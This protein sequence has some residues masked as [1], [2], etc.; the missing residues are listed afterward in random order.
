M[1]L[2]WSEK[3]RQAG[4]VLATAWGLLI[5]VVVVL[6]IYAYQR[7]AAHPDVA[8][9]VAPVQAGVPHV[10][11]DVPPLEAAPLPE[12]PFIAE[13]EEPAAPPVEEPVRS[14]PPAQQ[15][16]K[17][18]PP[19]AP[20]P[21]AEPKVEPKVESVPV[22]EPAPV[23]PDPIEAPAPEPA[24]APAVVEP[25]P[26]E[27]A[28]AEPAVEEPASPPAPVADLKNV[29]VVLT[30]GGENFT[31]LDVMPAGTAMVLGVIDDNTPRF[32]AKA[33][34]NNIQI[35]LPLPV[36]ASGPLPNLAAE[37]D[38]NRRLFAAFLDDLP[39]VDGLYIP[40]GHPF[41]KDMASFAALL[42]EAKARGLSVIGTIPQNLQTPTTPIPPHRAVDGELL[43]GDAGNLEGVLFVLVGE[44]DAV[45]VLTGPADLAFARALAAVQGYRFVQ[46]K[47]F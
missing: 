40:A 27:T 42:E 30:G 18:L 20:E 10:W 45:A 9:Q 31:L 38:E 41:N 36:A 43:A 28:A 33:H 19:P 6:A 16:V 37:P 24:A 23:A 25:A 12:A 4:V 14:L 32:V 7:D 3:Y 13:V 47:G 22:V 39:A 35:L 46:P 21:K 34:K 44:R 8:E 17:E 29:F 2:A 5:A 26:A 11:L 15:P 1:N